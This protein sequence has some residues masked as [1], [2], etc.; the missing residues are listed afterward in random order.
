MRCWHKITRREPPPVTYPLRIEGRKP[1]VSHRSRDPAMLR[2][3]DFDGI[4]H[5][6][7]GFSGRCWPR[8]QE[9]RRSNFMATLREKATL[10]S[11]GS[12]PDTK[13][14]ER[15]AAQAGAAPASARTATERKRN[16]SR[17]TQSALLRLLQF[18]FFEPIGR[19]ADGVVQE[20]LA[21]PGIDLNTHPERAKK[22][23]G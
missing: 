7:K 5:R 9:F 17:P 18:S 2:I 8:V 1:E 10:R 16:C 11:G 3:T 23:P 13:Q 22:L 19:Q 14:A 4:R 20:A 12:K 15:P 21:V 6:R